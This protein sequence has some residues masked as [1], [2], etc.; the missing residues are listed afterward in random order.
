MDS[1][2]APERIEVVDGSELVI[3]WEN[4]ATSRL[5]AAGLRAACPC[6]SCREDAGR[7]Q[8]ELVLGGPIPVTI[9]DAKLV[10]GYAL[11]FEFAPDGHG[12]GIYPFEALYELGRSGGSS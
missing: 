9:T 12:T 2:P 8:T 11:S 6:A 4:G 1:T 5:A 7:A 10:G 3:T